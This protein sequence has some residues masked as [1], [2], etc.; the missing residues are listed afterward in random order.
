MKGP[1]SSQNRNYG[2][3]LLKGLSMLF[4]VVLHTMGHGGILGAA[5]PKTGMYIAAWGLEIWCFCAVDVFAFTSGYVGIRG[6]N[7]RVNY[8]RYFQL[9]LE[10]LFYTVG[11]LLL[12]VTIFSHSIHR[13]DLINAVMPVTHKGYWYFT[14]YTGVIL[15][16]P[17]V[18]AFVNST[19][20]VSA[21]KWILFVFGVLVITNGHAD[22][23]RFSGGYSLIWILLLYTTGALMKKSG[24]GEKASKTCLVISI[25]ALWAITLVLKIFEQHITIRL[26]QVSYTSPSIVCIA[27]MYVLLFRKLELSEKTCRIIALLAP[28]FFAV[29]LINDNYLIRNKLL[30]RRFA[31]LADQRVIVMIVAVIGFAVAF[32]L[33]ALL[34]DAIRRKL[35]ELLQMNKRT[36][37]FEELLRKQINRLFAD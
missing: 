20:R 12:I 25:I 3:D 1:T 24:L 4:V 7:T 28:S 11:S 33:M 26:F 15:L 19:T 23:W 17:A 22:I 9:W 36:K 14:A 29:Y 37:C 10:V 2:I 18:K 6:D 5:T 8:S 30:T 34:I 13:T 27:I 35:F 16:S 21:K 31:F 32:M